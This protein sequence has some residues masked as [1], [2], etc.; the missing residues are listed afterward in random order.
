ML[1]IT[2]CPRN[3]AKFY[4]VNYYIKWVITSVT[5]SISICTEFALPNYDNAFIQ[6]PRFK[7][8]FPFIVELTFWDLC[9]QSLASSVCLLRHISHWV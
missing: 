4:I 6:T 3:S 5:C 1:A 2:I 7:L 9:D 8:R